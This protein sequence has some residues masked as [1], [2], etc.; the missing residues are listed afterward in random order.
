METEKFILDVAK[1]MIPVLTGFLA[2]AVKAISPYWK[3]QPKPKKQDLAYVSVIGILA[4]LSFGCWAGALAGAM[5]STSEQSGS[6]L[7]GVLSAQE[8][9]LAARE[10]VGYAYSLFVATVLVTGAYYFVLLSQQG[11]QGPEK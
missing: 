4:F 11:Y 7:C 6:I 10:Y 3:K 1:V 2:V 8:A 9:L 5:I